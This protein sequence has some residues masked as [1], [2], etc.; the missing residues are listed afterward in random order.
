MLEKL[1]RNKK[2]WIPIVVLVVVSAIVIGISLSVGMNGNYGN[3]GTEDIN[4]NGLDE[5]QDDITS[6]EDAITPTNS[7]DEDEGSSNVS[8]NNLCLFNVS[9][10]SS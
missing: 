3:N 4:D 8:E 7:W 1:L 5:V 6:T 10:L 9:C 2:I